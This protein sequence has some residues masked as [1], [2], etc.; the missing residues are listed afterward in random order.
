M[1]NFVINLVFRKYKLKYLV[2]ICNINYINCMEKKLVIRF[3][4][5][6]FVGSEF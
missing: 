3:C 2:K 4:N 5:F 1:Y 6:L